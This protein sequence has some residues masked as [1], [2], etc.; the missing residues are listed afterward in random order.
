MRHLIVAAGLCLSI[1]QTARSQD[2]PA[3]VDRIINFPTQYISKVQSKF[4][5][6][7]KQ[8]TQQTEKYLQDI[9]K[10]EKKLK[11][12]LYRIDSSAEQ[13]VFGDVQ[14]AYAKIS[15]KLGNATS[16]TD[17]VRRTEYS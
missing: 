8:L 1:H 2:I 16:F 5:Y 11:R 15:D 17:K 7:D 10:K 12:K 4:S 13:Q 6:I 3:P 14:S 9:A